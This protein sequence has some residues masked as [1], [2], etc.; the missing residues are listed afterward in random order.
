MRSAGMLDH[1]AADDAQCPSTVLDEI[2]PAAEA[3]NH[4]REASRRG[5]AFLFGVVQF[6]HDAK[7]D[8]ERGLRLWAVSLALQHPAT[9]GSSAA[10][11]ARS[12]GVTPAALSKHVVSF[13]RGH[14][15]P[16]AFYQKSEAARNVYRDTRNSQLS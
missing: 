6:L 14:S 3:E 1:D 10:S 16:P 4:Y 7:S 13:E 8:R 9:G 2:E 12:L 15:L 11:I 5:L